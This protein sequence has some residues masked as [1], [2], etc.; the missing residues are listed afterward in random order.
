MGVL[1]KVEDIDTDN[2]L[3]IVLDTPDIKR[4][5]GVDIN[6]LDSFLEESVKEEGK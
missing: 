1:D 5:D 6:E 2:T 4:I 3:L